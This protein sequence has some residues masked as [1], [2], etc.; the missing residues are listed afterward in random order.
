MSDSTQR[1]GGMSSFSLARISS[2]YAQYQAQPQEQHTPVYWNNMFKDLGFDGGVEPP[3]HAYANGGGYAAQAPGVP[4]AGSS[5]MHMHHAPPHAAQQAYGISY[6]EAPPEHGAYQNHAGYAG[7]PAPAVTGYS[8]GY[9][10][11]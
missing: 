1:G 11:R 6:R 3:Q 9:G 7:Y 2:T 4:E 8:A 5:T 10:G